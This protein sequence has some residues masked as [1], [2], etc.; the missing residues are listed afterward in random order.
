MLV[1]HPWVGNGEGNPGLQS[2]PRQAVGPQLPTPQMGVPSPALSGQ[3]GGLG[4]GTSGWMGKRE[5]HHRTSQ[6]P[7]KAGGLRQAAPQPSN[8]KAAQGC[9]ALGAVPHMTTRCRHSQ[10]YVL[11]TRLA[12][13]AHPPGLAL[14]G[15]SLPVPTAGADRGCQHAKPCSQ[16]QGLQGY[17]LPIGSHGNQP[18]RT[19]QHCVG[20]GGLGPPGA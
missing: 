2:P 15:R 13:L 16:V 1:P 6:V 20:E 10:Y 12:R 19:G 9:L 17:T 18:T 5:I 7:S 3:R 11:S 4:D 8:D 14:C